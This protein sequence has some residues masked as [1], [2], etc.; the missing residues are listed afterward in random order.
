MLEKT[1]AL[2][3]LECVHHFRFCSHKRQGSLGTAGA[4]ICPVR[5]CPRAPLSLPSQRFWIP[6]SWDLPRP[7]CLS[8]SNFCQRSVFPGSSCL[9][10]VKAG[11]VES[12][13]PQR[14]SSK[15][16]AHPAV[17]PRL[18]LAA[19]YTGV[20][21]PKPTEPFTSFPGHQDWHTA[22]F[23]HPTCLSHD[24]LGEVY[25]SQVLSMKETQCSPGPDLWC[26][27]PIG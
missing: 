9:W 26:W 14:V 25:L 8:P 27:I 20:L 19:F 2:G 10:Y 11:T 1:P 16:T 22:C 17:Q 21:C 18:C 6:K 12:T 3:V 23:I 13:A 24:A 15:E 4:C 7:T 5:K